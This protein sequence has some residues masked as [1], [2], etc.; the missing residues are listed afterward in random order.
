MLFR[1]GTLLAYCFGSVLTFF[2][3]GPFAVESYPRGSTAPFILAM[4]ASGTV[5]LIGLWRALGPLLHFSLGG[6]LLSIVTLQIPVLVLV[7]TQ[8]YPQL[9][10][11]GLA[12]LGVWIL[13]FSI[14]LLHCAGRRMPA[15]EML[16]DAL[17]V[18]VLNPNYTVEWAKSVDDVWCRIPRVVAGRRKHTDGTPDYFVLIR[19]NNAPLLRVDLFAETDEVFAFQDWV[20]WQN[21]V[22]LGWGNRISLVRL[23]TQ[24]AREFPL[25]AYFGSMKFVSPERGLLVASAERLFLIHLDGALAWQSDALGLDGVVIREIANG[26]V[27]GEGEWD[28]PGGWKPFQVRLNSGHTVFAGQLD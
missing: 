16:P 3:V 27:S 13:G 22:A 17:P 23:D 9:S 5:L 10:N 26:I 12:L 8:A 24:T 14:Y 7:N 25:G 21:T 4:S 11:L 19:E 1:K 20:A 28:P 2:L 18:G 15:D 6:L